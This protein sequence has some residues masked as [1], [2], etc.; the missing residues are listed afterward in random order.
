LREGGQL[1]RWLP[2]EVCGESIRQG[3]CS[4]HWH[5]VE[6]F[7]DVRTYEG[8]EG[9]DDAFFYADIGFVLQVGAVQ[10][11]RSNTGASFCGLYLASFFDAWSTSAAVVVSF[12]CGPLLLQMSR[13]SMPLVPPA[14]LYCC[15]RMC[16][17]PFLSR[18]MAEWVY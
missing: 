3:L 2:A 10:E 5:G 13:S 4:P 11:L 12:A 8:G 9:F 1:R 18:V 17:M 7:R 15:L 14:G 16:R 6:W